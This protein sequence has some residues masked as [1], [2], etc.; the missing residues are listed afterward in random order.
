[1]QE[2]WLQFPWQSPS[3]ALSADP[4]ISSGWM[5]DWKA[6]FPKAKFF[7]FTPAGENGGGLEEDEEQGTFREREKGEEGAKPPGQP[8]WGR[9]WGDL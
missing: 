1:M 8:F 2:P 3:T 4:M 5:E 6:G 9:L 7:A